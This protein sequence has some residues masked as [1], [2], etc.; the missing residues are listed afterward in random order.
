MFTPEESAQ[1]I[2]EWV[3]PQIP[4]DDTVL[5]PFRGDG[6]FFDKI[7]NEKYYCEI[8]D[9]ID[10]FNYTKKVDWAVSNPPDF[11]KLIIFHSF[12]INI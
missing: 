2:M 5:E 6:V 1:K 7:P 3:L 4:I 11:Q 8:D 12:K 9:G 10:F